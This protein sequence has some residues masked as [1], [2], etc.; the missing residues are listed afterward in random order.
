MKKT[1]KKVLSRIP[2][3]KLKSKL[4]TKPTQNSFLF[5]P[6]GLDRSRSKLDLSLMFKE[7]QEITPK[8]KSDEIVCFDN[9][10]DLSAQL[11]TH[12][13][14]CEDE[15]QMDNMLFSDDEES[16]LFEK[17]DTGVTTEDN[18]SHS[19]ENPIPMSQEALDEY[20]FSTDSLR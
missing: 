20:L 5:S 1:G 14:K 8:S 17:M 9:F 19:P 4:V 12:D 10:G 7:S 16:D 18:F 6:T 3:S 15:T 13:C 2:L 11:K